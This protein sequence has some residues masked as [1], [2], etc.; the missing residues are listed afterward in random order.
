MLSSCQIAD[1]I[2]EYNSKRDYIS[3]D[4]LNLM[5]K[6][7]RHFQQSLVDNVIVPDLIQSAFSCYLLHGIDTF[8]NSYIPIEYKDLPDPS[9]NLDSSE[10]KVFKK[11]KVN[12]AKMKGR[13]VIFPDVF[14]TIQE[15][16]KSFR[17]N[18]KAM[19]L[20]HDCKYRE[21]SFYG[22]L[23]LD[24]H[25]VKSKVRLSAISDKG[26]YIN[27]ISTSDASPD[28]FFESSY[29]S[30]MH[31]FEAFNFQMLNKVV[32]VDPKMSR[33]YIVAVESV[34]PYITQVYEMSL[35]DE[36]IKAGNM[37]VRIALDR[38][39]SSATSGNYKGYDIDSNDPDGIFDM[40]L[41]ESVYD[42]YF[43]SKI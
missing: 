8:L 23:D 24:G 30:G 1:S 41:P 27:L 14:C 22:E 25:I 34:S 29:K 9:K 43:Q 19:E 7:P 11:A 26:Y 6:S 33:A 3:G 17:G 35:A 2:T 28:A 32:D 36:F 42:I 4:S 38:L 15:M 20:L 31:T 10:N 16:L 13:Q 12:E 39:K 18:K 21:N 40:E 5:L 37:E